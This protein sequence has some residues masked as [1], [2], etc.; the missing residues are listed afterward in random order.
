MVSPTGWGLCGANTT[1][2]NWRQDPQFLS[3]IKFG[4]AGLSGGIPVNGSTNENYASWSISLWARM[5]QLTGDAVPFSHANNTDRNRQLGYDHG[6]NHWFASYTS[7][8]SVF[9]SVVSPITVIVNKWYH[10]V[11]TFDGAIEK[12]YVNGLLSASTNFGVA[13]QSVATQ[14]TIGS[15]A[16]SSTVMQ[17]NL[18]HIAEWNR[19]I[20]AEEVGVLFRT[21]DVL[22]VRYG[23]SVGTPPSSGQTPFVSP[24]LYGG[25][26]PFPAGNS[27]LLPPVGAF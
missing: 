23:P 13:A 24:I 14:T 6:T 4:S 9:K 17:G 16:L 1:P 19:A 18:A 3:V 2:A 12:I 20:S 10:L 8:S 11:G 7:A 5:S 27:K 25:N 15:L 22:Q 26:V 21:A